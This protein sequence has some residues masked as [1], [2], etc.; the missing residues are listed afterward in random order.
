MKRIALT[1]G[2][3]EGKSTVL[4]YLRDLGI[5]VES[6]DHIVSQ[7]Y[8]NDSVLS[9]LR[10][11]L[12]IEGPVTR[13]IV[14]N[15]LQK[16]PEIFQTLN[17]IFH[18]RTLDRILKSSAQVVEVPLLFETCIQAQF[19]R[20]WVVTCGVEE[21]RRRL[22]SRYENESVAEQMLERQLPSRVK[23]AFA[24][25]IVRTNRSEAS[26]LAFVARWVKEEFV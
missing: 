11:E 13:E 5:A 18:Q 3:A 19:D 10:A 6:S 9:E 22:L 2:I 23:C 8:E 15:L 17:R 16:R 26:V 21:Q 24:D 7:L 1:G 20:V 4:G 12:A 25:V 14:R